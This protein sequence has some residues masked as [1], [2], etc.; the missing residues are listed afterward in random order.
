MKQFFINVSL[1]L[2]TILVVVFCTEGVLRFTPYKGLLPYEG[3]PQYYYVA[4][5][6]AG[7][8]I[9]P[10]F[11]SA[12]HRFKDGSYNIWSNSLGCFDTPYENQTPYIY[13]TGDSFAW[14]FTAFGDKWGTLLQDVSGV[15]VVKCGVPGYGTKQELTK[16]TK[17]LKQLP[18]PSLILVSY[19]NNDEV[20]DAAFP[21]SLVYEG[22]LIKNLSGDPS[23]TY[24]DLEQKLPQYA[25]WAES[26]CMWNMPAHPTLQ[27]GKCYLR[28]H[29]I[30]YLLSQSAVKAL[31]PTKLLQKIGI[32]N[33]APPSVSVEEA[34]SKEH[35]QNVGAFKTLARSESSRLVF[36]L[37][38][39][40]EDTMGSATTT[41]ASIQ[42]YL[43]EQ[44][45][46]YINPLT[47]FRA[48]A[49][50]TSTSLYWPED[51]HFNEKGN[52]L[53][54]LIVTKELIERGLAPQSKLQATEEKMKMEFGI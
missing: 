30:L 15:R 12:V 3:T 40:K 54:G 36:V 44:G 14:G 49:S 5:K 45:I 43:Q 10:N 26:Y 42:K 41:Y 27:R 35:L 31:V 37:I 48:V 6:D 2:S 9:A 23:L 8:D 46:D 22:K 4:T 28:N 16:A 13:L 34:D 19:F 33:E 11:A 50:A 47:Q 20:D 52:R 1:A 29:S 32:V 39:S 17:L 25:T 24:D 7:Y 51:L 21:N 18:R 38:P 53:L